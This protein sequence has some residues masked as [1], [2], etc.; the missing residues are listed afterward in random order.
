MKSDDLYLSEVGPV[1]GEFVV[2]SGGCQSGCNPTILYL[3]QVG[4]FPGE[5]VV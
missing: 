4:P 1:P 5:F 2:Y 3:G